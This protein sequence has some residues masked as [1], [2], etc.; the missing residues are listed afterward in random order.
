MR[1]QQSVLWDPA[2]G[3]V[4]GGHV[5]R[6]GGIVDGETVEPQLS[7]VEAFQPGQ[8]PKQGGLTGPVRAHHRHDLAGLD[9]EGHIHPQVAPDQLASQVHCRNP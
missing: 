6:V 8:E 7:M 3:T 1:E 4:V 2:D 5:A 9:R